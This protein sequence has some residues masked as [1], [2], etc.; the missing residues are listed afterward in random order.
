[1]KVEIQE[2]SH[3]NITLNTL[4]KVAVRG[5]HTYNVKWFLDNEFVGDMN[6]GGGNWG[7]FENKIGDWRIEFWQGDNLVTTFNNNLQG[8]NVLIITSFGIS[9]KGKV[10]NMSNLT[11]F[12]NETE[13]KYGCNV[14]VYF[15]GSEKFDLDFKVLR[16]NTDIDFVLMTEMQ[17]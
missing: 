9:P 5:E 12:I 15:A 10:P 6:L 2:N 14:Y 16:M 11:N 8:E 3:A 7:G 17:F 1:M 13:S 4:A